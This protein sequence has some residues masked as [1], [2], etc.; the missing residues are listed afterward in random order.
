MDNNKLRQHLKAKCDEE[1]A[2]AAKQLLANPNTEVGEHM[3][4]IEAYSKLLAVMQTPSRRIWMTGI[5]VG[6]AVV[7]GLSLTLRVSRTPIMLK[8]QT[9]VLGLKLARPLSWPE[10][11]PLAVSVA[12]DGLTTV[13]AP[14]L[15]SQKLQSAPAGAWIRIVEGSVSLGKL[16]VQKDDVIEMENVSQTSLDFYVYPHSA[17]HVQLQVTGAAHVFAGAADSTSIEVQRDLL[18]PETIDLHRG[19]GAVPMPFRVR[20]RSPWRLQNLRVKELRF[21]RQIPADEPGGIAFISTIKMGTLALH[22]TTESVTL[23]TGD[24]LSL[25]G[26]EGRLVELQGGDGIDLIFE[27]TVQEVLIGPEGFKRNLMP[28]WFTYISHNQPLI[29]VWSS[30]VFLWGILWGVRTTLFP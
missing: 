20:S 8:L 23:Q 14:G 6:I 16:Q 12:F 22:D 26:V 15:F 9:E 10:G 13:E 17:A 4:R 30:I 11:L 18:I 29:A 21:S 3:R 24:Q 19:A 25:A 27:G 7:L 2:E 1:I 5:A 28:S